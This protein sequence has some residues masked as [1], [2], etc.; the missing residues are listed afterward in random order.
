[1]TVSST[2]ATYPSM[3]AFDKTEEFCY[4]LKKIAKSC[5]NDRRPSLDNVY[6]GMCNDFND[7]IKNEVTCPFDFKSRKIERKEFSKLKSWT[8]DYARNN[9]AKVNIFL[10]DP[11]V[12]KYQR[13]EKITEITFVG[14]IGGILG[15]FL[16]F[17]FISVIEILY[18][19]FIW[20]SSCIS[21][22]K[23]CH[24]S[25]T[26]PVGSWKSS[27]TILKA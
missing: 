10:K 20:T 22:S 7:I 26:R 15:L 16:G 19:V 3:L 14:T 17:S 4:V 9:I 2:H 5:K 11:F 18:L 27:N 21:K 23:K 13:E 25:K 24:S 6:P 8:V 1:M 12:Q